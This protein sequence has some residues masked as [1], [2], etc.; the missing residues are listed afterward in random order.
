MTI[1]RKDL[2]LRHRGLVQLELCER[3]PRALGRRGDIRAR[4]VVGRDD[5]AVR[6]GVPR[7]AELAYRRGAQAPERPS[8]VAV[9]EQV[10][11]RYA[12]GVTRVG[13]EAEADG[14]LGGRRG[15][16]EHAVRSLRRM[17]L[18]RTLRRL[19]EQRTDDLFKRVRPR[20]PTERQRQLELA[21]RGG[22]VTRGGAELRADGVLEVEFA[23][24]V[25][26]GGRG[27]TEPRAVFRQMR[28]AIHILLAAAA[29]AALGG[30]ALAHPRRLVAPMLNPPCG[31]PTRVAA[32]MMGP[33]RNPRNN[34]RNPR[35]N[36][37][38]SRRNAP[39]RRGAKRAEDPARGRLQLPALPEEWTENPLYQRARESF[40]PVLSRSSATG[41]Q[42]SPKSRPSKTLAKSCFR[43]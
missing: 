37:R 9:G 29:A 23:R 31:A 36:P 22:R 12:V 38:G 42:I 13:S 39:Q 28:S 1:H 14:G 6:V 17:A 18:L 33:P 8:V 21:T 5:G 15:S 43:C 19:A 4:V 40:M 11:A 27:V 25:T 16:L 24:R 26:R 34:P 2:Q 30:G 3:A 41:P 7:R 32:P 10:R 35:D 20:A